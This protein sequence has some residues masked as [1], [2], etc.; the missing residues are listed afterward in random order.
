M[1]GDLCLFEKCVVYLRVGRVA[2]Q[3]LEVV[4]NYENPRTPLIFRNLTMYFLT[5]L[6]DE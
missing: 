5:V 1:P 2:D 6:K 4:Q 3:P